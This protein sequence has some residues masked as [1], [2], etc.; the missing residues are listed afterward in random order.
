MCILLL[1]VNW[2]LNYSINV[3]G[4]SKYKFRRLLEEI[5]LI[6]FMAVSPPIEFSVQCLI[7]NILT[8]DLLFIKRFHVLQYFS[9]QILSYIYIYIYIHIYI[10]I[11]V[12]VCVYIYMW[13]KML[14]FWEHTFIVYINVVNIKNKYWKFLPPNKEPFVI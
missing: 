4:S 2:I 9:L 14:S 11:Y 7:W 8:S 13:H 5:I 3:L 10:Y 1:V 6:L 12:C